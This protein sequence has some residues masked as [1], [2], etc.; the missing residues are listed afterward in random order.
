MKTAL[1]F[2]LLL[3]ALVAGGCAMKHGD[4]HHGDKKGMAEECDCCGE[5]GC[6]T[7]PAK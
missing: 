3:M 7:Q 5:K 1:T 4:H 2:A 6:T